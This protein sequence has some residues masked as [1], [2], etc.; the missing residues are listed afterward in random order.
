[1]LPLLFFRINR[2]LPPQEPGTMFQRHV[3]IPALALLAL[4]LLLSATPAPAEEGA[5]LYDLERCIEQALETNRDLL[6]DREEEEKAGD[7]IREAWAGALPQVGFEGTFNR[8]IERPSFFFRSDGG[9]GEEESA[10]SGGSSEVIKI[11]IGARYDYT[12]GFSLRQ[13]LWLAGKV[14]AALKAAKLYDRSASMSVEAR[15]QLVVLQTK[16]AFYGAL[17]AKEEVAVFRIA[18]EQA[19]SHLATTRLRRERGLASDFEVLRAE[20]VVSEAVPANIAAA[21]GARQTLNELK[22]ILGVDMERTIDV[23]GEFRFTPWMSEQI[24]EEEARAVERR[25]DRKALELQVKLL[26]QNVRAVRGDLF[27]NFYLTGNYNFTGSSNDFDRFRDE[28]R[29][30]SAA[31]GIYVSFPFWTSGAATAR[32][33]QARSERRIAE[34]RLEQMEETVRKEVFAARYDMESAEEQSSATEIGVTR[35]EKAFEIAETR[36][37]NGLLTQIELLD[38]RLALTRA[39][40]AHLRALHDVLLARAAWVR[41]VGIPWGEEW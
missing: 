5:E 4:Q 31:A 32:L 23:S 28:E 8:N 37:E 39:R 12:A 30:R 20:V 36:Y 22:L 6:I 19:E 24:R 25:P 14:G 27:P 38:V 7:R 18:L 2:G 3:F 16:A 41:V 9:F 29:S 11:E 1:M 10:D 26:E 21:N 40:V 33:R 15:E 35:S 17:L 13:P 34:I